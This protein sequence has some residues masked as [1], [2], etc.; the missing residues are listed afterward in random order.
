M[1]DVD[2]GKAMKVAADVSCCQDWVQD[3]P[4]SGKRAPWVTAY[5]SGGQACEVKF[6]RKGIGGQNPVLD[7]H[8]L[9]QG[10]LHS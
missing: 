9:R 3:G 2:P 10:R 1:R 6:D 7:S 5:P 4:A 8:Y